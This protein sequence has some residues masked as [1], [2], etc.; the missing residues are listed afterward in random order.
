MVSTVVGL[1]S[2][3]KTNLLN[4]DGDSPNTPVCYGTDTLVNGACVPK[5]GWYRYDGHNFNDGTQGILWK[6]NFSNE[7]LSYPYITIED[8]GSNTWLNITYLSGYCDDGTA[9]ILQVGA[10]LYRQNY[11]PDE[12]NGDSVFFEM[13]PLKE[14]FGVYLMEFSGRFNAAKDT[15]RGKVEFRYG[16]VY[17]KEHAP[18]E[19]VHFFKVKL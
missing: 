4:A 11:W 17:Y 19:D 9:N 6:G 10:G 12:Q 1:V 8:T 7:Y 16:G 13:P 2:C 14:Y 3:K 18:M 15:I 5:P